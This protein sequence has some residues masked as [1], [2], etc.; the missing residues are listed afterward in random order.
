MF[1]TPDEVIV[2]LRRYEA[3]GVDYFN[4]SASFGMPPAE[5]TKSLRLFIDEVMPAFT[6]V[7]SRAEALCA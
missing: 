1:G 5:Q 6:S 4:Y 7:R 3:I 2:K